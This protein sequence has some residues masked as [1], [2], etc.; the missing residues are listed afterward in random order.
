VREVLKHKTIEKVYFVEIDE[1]VITISKKFFPSVSSGV[2]DPR[3]EIR[4]MDGADFLAKRTSADID[5]VIIDSTDIIGFARSLFTP[6][7]FTAVRNCLSGNGLFVT[8]T[9]SLHF[10]KDMVVEIQEALKKVF[11]L[12][13]LYTTAIATYPGNWWAF[14]IASKGVSPREV[15][16]KRKIKT[17]YYSDEIHQQSFMPGGL[18]EKLMKRQ[19]KW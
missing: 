10:H 8:H 17:K 12:V 5:A 4:I 19:L 3:V 18:Y 7:F 11:P 13:D 14:A 9:E 2:D 1:E 15:R 16:N 6:E